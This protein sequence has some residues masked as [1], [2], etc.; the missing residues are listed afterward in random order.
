ME[1]YAAGNQNWAL[2]QGRN[3]E[4][5]IANN[6]GVLMYDAE[7]WKLYPMNS[8]VRSVAFFDGVLYSGSYMDFGYWEKQATGDLVYQS[9]VEQY[10]IQ[11]IEDEQFWQIYQIEDTLRRN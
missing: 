10:G 4:I 5:Y 9:L 1:E 2:T 3:D 7:R 11:L 8:I 6:E